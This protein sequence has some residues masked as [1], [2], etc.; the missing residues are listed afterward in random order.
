MII[1]FFILS[2]CSSS[3]TQR[4]L[5]SKNSPNKPDIQAQPLPTP[6]LENERDVLIVS[7]N[8][9]IYINKDG[10]QMRAILDS[11]ND[12]SIG[13]WS[14]DGEKIIYTEYSNRVNMIEGEPVS[15]SYSIK[16][17]NINSGEIVQLVQDGQDDVSTPA[18]PSYSLD[19]SII[20]FQGILGGAFNIFTISP[21][22]KNL[23]RIT[24]NDSWQFNGPY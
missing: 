15:P 20:A 16:T 24:K 3:D 17:V 14:P 2:A 11:T 9:G 6:S 22:G 19:G 4:V 18:A 5:T 23:K 10:S 7:A 1:S 21:D 8:E 13:G 12:V